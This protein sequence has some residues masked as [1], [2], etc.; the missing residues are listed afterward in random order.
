MRRFRLVLLS[1]ACW[2]IASSLS[3]QELARKPNIV[4]ILIDDM[5]Y[6]DLGCYGGQFAPTPNLDKLAQQ[7]IRFKQFYVAAPI[8]SPSRT[9]FVTGMFPG[10]WKINSYLQT[11][12]GNRACE[13]AD[14]LDP[15]APFLAR[16]LKSL[17]YATGHFGKWHLGGGRDVQNAP[18]PRAYGFDEHHVNFEGMGPRFDS[19][20]IKAPVTF[21]GKEIPRHRFTQYW[22]DRSLDFIRRHR[23]EPFFVQLWPMDTHD[24]H[25]PRDFN[26]KQRRQNFAHV[27]AELDVQL[28]RLF[29]ELRQLGL[30][31]NTIVIVTSDNGPNPSF[32][33]ERTGDLRGQKWSLYE[34]G[35]RMAFL[36]RWTGTIPANRENKDTVLASVDLFPSLAKLVG[37]PIP[38]NLD[39]EDLSA[40]LLGQ[41]PVRKKL[42]FWE[43]GR[44]DNAY[45][46]APGTDRS[47]NVAVRDGKWMLL[48]NADGTRLELYDM[49]KDERQTMNLAA[50]H[51]EVA[52]RLRDTAIAWR[53]SLP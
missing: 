36:V 9:G 28:G 21:E 2:L 29:T 40:A 45:L 37:A 35:I 48:V 47:P 16:L 26:P 49:L 34:G 44:N 17:G 18:L 25:K 30:E 38:D 33:H 24:P 50:T 12:Q 6:G 11:R 5:G 41:E 19:E 1:L 7:G 53:K 13:Q 22:V 32:D 15:Q 23:S 8:C 20:G 10:R 31:E 3:A 51:A 39:G 52:R 27:L 4:F 43:Y 46:F 42:L 14:W